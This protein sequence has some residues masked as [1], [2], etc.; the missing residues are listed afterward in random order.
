MARAPDRTYLDVRPPEWL[1]DAG[2]VAPAEIVN[3]EVDRLP[4]RSRTG[5]IALPPAAQALLAFGGGRAGEAGATDRTRGAFM[6]G[7]RQVGRARLR[8]AM[9]LSRLGHN[10][11]SLIAYF[12]HRPPP[13][14]CRIKN[15]GPECIRL[16]VQPIS[17]MREH[18]KKSRMPSSPAIVAI[19]HPRPPASSSDNWMRSSLAMAFIPSRTKGRCLAL[20]FCDFAIKSSIKLSRAGLSLSKKATK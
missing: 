16:I 14:A 3:V 4:D 2:I 7:T 6:A 15:Y 10:Q 19:F 9:P 13:T 18:R 20:R 11:P 8:R 5:L 1:P 17:T 12:G